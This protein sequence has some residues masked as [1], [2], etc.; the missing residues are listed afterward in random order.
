MFKP[1]QLICLGFGWLMAKSFS[2]K[3]RWVNEFY[4]FRVN[5][6]VVHPSIQIAHWIILIFEYLTTLVREKGASCSRDKTRTAIV[7]CCA[8]QMPNEWCFGFVAYFYKNINCAMEGK[9]LAVLQWNRLIQRAQHTIH[10][11]NAGLLLP[12]LFVKLHPLSGWRQH[13]LFGRPYSA[14]LPPS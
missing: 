7:R 5:I 1:F 10:A 8:R 4:F 3:R 6:E 12:Y 9:I 11:Q 14:F 2:K 13:Y